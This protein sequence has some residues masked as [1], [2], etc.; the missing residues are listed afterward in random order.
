MFCIFYP[1]SSTF[2]AT[3]A[4]TAINTNAITT[5]LWIH[6]VW[7]TV[8]GNLHVLSS[9]CTV[10]GEGNWKSFSQPV[11][12][13]RRSRFKSSELASKNCCSCINI[14]DP[15]DTDLFVLWLLNFKRSVFSKDFFIITFP[16]NNFQDD[17][18]AFPYL[19]LFMFFF[20]CAQS[21]SLILLGKWVGW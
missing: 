4:I 15:A 13:R 17:A 14:E 16:Q 2:S 5:I 6:I 21:K 20:Y 12:C 1:T 18:L 19:L 9:I 7:N 11:K 3:P 8:Q 10:E